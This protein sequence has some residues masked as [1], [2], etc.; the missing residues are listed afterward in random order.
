MYYQVTFKILIHVMFFLCLDKL[1]N[2]GISVWVDVSGLRAGV[3]FLS[4]IG[5]AIIDAKVNKTLTPICSHH[6]LICTTLC[7]LKPIHCAIDIQLTS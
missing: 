2:S 7:I 3:D 1:E 6:T 4:K 5:Q